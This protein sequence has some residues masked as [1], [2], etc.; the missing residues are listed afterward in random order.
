MRS[1]LRKDCARVNSFHISARTHHHCVV[2][3]A[4]DAHEDHDRSPPES[5]DQMQ[6]C[7]ALRVLI[8]ND[9]L[10]VVERQSRT[11]RS[12]WRLQ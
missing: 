12:S 1:A 8:C 9:G 11:Q 5:R 3:N 4:E 10:Q 6:A 2:V 7:N